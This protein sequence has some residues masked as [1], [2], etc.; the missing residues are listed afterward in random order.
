MGIPKAAKA[1][2]KA[3]EVSCPACGRVYRSITA[4]VSHLS[5]T[6]MFDRSR[7]GKR[8]FCGGRAADDELPN[9][10]Q[11]RTKIAC[12]TRRKLFRRLTGDASEEQRVMAQSL[13][14]CLRD[15]DLGLRLEWSS[16]TEV[17]SQAIAIA[18]GNGMLIVPAMVLD[19]VMFK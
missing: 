7:I 15:P 2:A 14:D 11:Q 1:K 8:R 19:R 18:K 13:K 17:S 12:V 6:S 4:V 5:T 10:V 3:A 16:L 9:I